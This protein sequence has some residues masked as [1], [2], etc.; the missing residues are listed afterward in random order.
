MMLVVAPAEEQQ[1]TTMIGEEIEE[2]CVRGKPPSAAEEDSQHDT[3][4]AMSSS[5]RDHA[6]RADKSGGKRSSKPTSSSG[7]R[8]R[9]S[10]SPS[11]TASMDGRLAKSSSSSRA[12]PRV[13]S[14]SRPSSEMDDRGGKCSRSQRR[15]S[16][17]EGATLGD[18]EGSQ[19]SKPTS[20]SG[21]KGRLLGQTHTKQKEGKGDR[22]SS[23]HRRKSAQHLTESN[24]D[25][26]NI[27][28]SHTASGVHR[29]GGSDQ[30][31]ST[32]S[33]PRHSSSD[34]H[35]RRHRSKSRSRSAIPDPAERGTERSARSTKSEKSE[36]ARRPSKEQSESTPDSPP[37]KTSTVP[38]EPSSS[39]Q[40]SVKV[41]SALVKFRKVLAMSKQAS[42]SAQK[43][44]D[45]QEK[46]TQDLGIENLGKVDTISSLKE[47]SRSARGASSGH[48][49]REGDSKHSKHKGSSHNRRRNEHT[50]G[51]S[52]R[53]KRKP[54]TGATQSSAKKP[55]T[56]PVA[57]DDFLK[58]AL[59]C[60]GKRLSRASLV[61]KEPEDKKE[62]TK[63]EE[64]VLQHKTTPTSNGDSQKKEGKEEEAAETQ[65][66]TRTSIKE[67]AAN[68][69]KSSAKVST[70]MLKFQQALAL[71]R[72]ATQAAKT[73]QDTQNKLLGEVH[74]D[75]TASDSLARASYRAKYATTSAASPVS[76][77]DVVDPAEVD[78]PKVPSDLDG[79]SD[80]DSE[81]EIDDVNEDDDTISDVATDSED[82]D[83]VAVQTSEYDAT[84]NEVDT[85]TPAVPTVVSTDSDFDMDSDVDMHSDVDIDS[86]DDL[87]S[88]NELDATI[89][90]INSGN[91][92][93]EDNTGDCGSDSESGNSNVDMDSD[94]DI[95]SACDV[96]ETQQTK[97]GGFPMVTDDSGDGDDEDDEVVACDSA[98]LQ[99]GNRPKPFEH[100]AVADANN[101]SGTAVFEI[102]VDAQ[103]IELVKAQIQKMIAET[104]QSED[105]L[106]EG[107]ALS[108]TVSEETEAEATIPHNGSIKDNEDGKEHGDLGEKEKM[109]LL[110]RSL[111]FNASL[112][113]SQ[114]MLDHSLA[115]FKTASDDTAIRK[116]PNLA[117]LGLNRGDD[118]KASIMTEEDS[119][120][121]SY[122]PMSMKKPEKGASF[123]DFDDDYL[124]PKPVAQKSEKSTKPSRKDLP[125]KPSNRSMRKSKSIGEKPEKPVSVEVARKLLNDDCI[126]QKT[127][128]SGRMR[129]PI[130]RSQSNCSTMRSD[131]ERKSRTSSSSADKDKAR[132]S[133]RS[134]GSERSSKRTS[135][136]R[137]R[138]LNGLSS[139][140]QKG[141]TYSSEKNEEGR[142]PSSRRKG[143]SRTKSNDVTSESRKSS[144]RS[145]SRSRNTEKDDR[146]RRSRK[147]TPVV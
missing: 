83:E 78:S 137:S 146:E 121:L 139:F 77:V 35:K 117:K 101:A 11:R 88:D 20:K 144:S 64:P 87:D 63:Q 70:A 43:Y 22:E 126:G 59:S 125:R 96:E 45:D 56:S 57:A 132:S 92:R 36:R 95:D 131:R 58:E 44:R 33:L 67:S 129:N 94:D 9:N 81:I 51:G 25:T 99:R 47:N 16:N 37:P 136:S 104:Q 135:G 93:K 98:D 112:S 60:V 103:D 12:K 74:A 138:T 75:K 140:S 28:R 108:Q 4:T 38:P 27:T 49:R 113:G 111:S 76:P 109:R 147:T 29:K 54:R 21:R 15:S 118:S 143:P 128:S 134:K 107:V 42:A 6:R 19:R 102:E 61:K 86:D 127:R 73:Q 66:A 142:K 130:S 69:L 106:A 39:L 80:I 52:S 48:H 71:S 90:S 110:G 8:R 7:T 72:S 50:D 55:D 3:E 2:D 24:D 79:D 115:D 145:V 62:E 1:T 119:Q 18:A 89:K 85:T 84:E 82:D 13:H 34:S 30:I 5:E 53:S 46:Q 124:L 122:L 114:S 10:K 17:V 14:R 65:S 26:H 97:D 31:S 116:G 68:R 105:G 120:R 133:D 23:R 100:Q 41:A 123:D 141:T 40:S 91:N 32:G